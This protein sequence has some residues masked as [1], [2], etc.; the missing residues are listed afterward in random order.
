MR[1]RLL[2]LAGVLF[3]LGSLTG[4]QKKDVRPGDIAGY[5]EGETYLSMWVHS[6]EETEEG[7]AYKASV[8]SFNEEY[9]GTYFADI[10]FVPRNDSGGGYSDKVNASVMSGGL[11]DVLT[12]DGP[13]IAAYASNGIIQPLADIPEEER[14]IYLPS[15]IEQGTYNGRLHALGVMESSVGLYYNKAILKEA[16]IEVPDADHPWT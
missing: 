12:V 10:E 9:D 6:I 3:A 4:C 14:A 1:K 13:N 5:D 7:Q 2:C 15:I 16:G 8:E 11:P